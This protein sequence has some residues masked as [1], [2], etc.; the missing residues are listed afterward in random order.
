[1]V[2]IH[3]TNLLRNKNEE[4]NVICSNMPGHS[5]DHIKG[6]NS[7]TENVKANVVYRMRNRQEGESIRTLE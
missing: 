4:K 1:M 5:R 3:K 7:D 6:R 2:H